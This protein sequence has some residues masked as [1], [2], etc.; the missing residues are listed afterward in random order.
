[1]PVVSGLVA[2][3]EYRCDGNNNTRG[4]TPAEIIAMATISISKHTL[5]GTSTEE[6]ERLKH[7]ANI[8][9]KGWLPVVPTAENHAMVLLPQD[10]THSYIGSFDKATGQIK[11][12]ELTSEEYTLEAGQFLAKN[13]YAANNSICVRVLPI[14]EREAAI[15]AQFEIEKAQWILDNTITKT[16]EDGTTTEIVPTVTEEVVAILK[17]EAEKLV[18]AVELQLLKLGAEFITNITDPNSIVFANEE[19]IYSDSKTW[20]PKALESLGF[21]AISNTIWP[22]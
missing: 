2:K 19:L 7:L 12:E 16:E 10:G 8:T 13:G 22:S 4:V 14:L 6:T 5:E 17:E 3:Y 1:M 11:Y 18:P 15:S 20:T 21:L 9:D